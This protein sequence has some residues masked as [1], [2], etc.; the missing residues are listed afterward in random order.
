MNKFFCWLFKHQFAILN[1]QAGVFGFCQKCGE[2][3]ELHF[4]SRA[5]F[6]KFNE[7]LNLSKAEVKQ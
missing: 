7:W 1:T 2:V 5:G 3:R 6:A 4:V